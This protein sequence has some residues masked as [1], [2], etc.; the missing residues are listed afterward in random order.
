MSAAASFSA[1]AIV[2]RRQGEPVCVED[3]EVA[4]LE[5]DE[6][7]LRVAATGICHTDLSAAAGVLPVEVPVVLGHEA[8]GVV[9]AVGAAVRRF[10][11]GDRAV[12]SVVNHCGH[13]ARCEAGYPP[14][15]VHRNEGR[16]RYAQNGA[17]IEQAY[18]T[19]TFAERIAVAER[20]L[21]RVPDGVPFDVAAVTGC[22]VVTGMGAVLTIARVSPGSTVAVMGCGGVGMAA[23]MAARLAGAERV[24]AVD[25]NPQRRELARQLGADDASLPDAEALRELQPDG[26]DYAFES[27]GR[28]EAMSLA[29]AVTGA[30]GTTVLMGLPAPE[31][32]L[33]LPVLHFL[34]AEKRLLA[35]NMGR[36]RPNLDFDRYFRL[37][38]RGRLPLDRLVTARLPLDDAATAFEQAERGEGIRTVVTM[39]GTADGNAPGR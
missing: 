21:V 25:P 23:V 9:E 22:A 4:P 34:F 11:P 16:K 3:I 5:T 27:A 15:C 36:L 37:F 24:V 35:C 31:S 29:V 38:L 7:L 26:F 10:R 28:V 32:V 1:R 2:L 8:A 18:G 39:A 19:G 6:V 17:S 20:S 12:V 14:L 33:P 13:C 30:A